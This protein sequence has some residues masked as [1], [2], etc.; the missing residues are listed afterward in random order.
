MKHFFSTIGCPSA[1]RS[2]AFANF[3]AVSTAGVHSGPT[4]TW[5]PWRLTR[6]ITT[7]FSFGLAL[8][9]VTPTNFA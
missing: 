1:P 2:S 3:T 8:P 5:P 6:P 7:G 4:W 9:G